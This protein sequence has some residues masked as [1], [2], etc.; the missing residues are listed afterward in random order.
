[1]SSGSEYPKLKD[2]SSMLH[3]ML[4]ET[5]LIKN[6]DNPEYMEILLDGRTCL[7]ELFA[8]IDKQIKFKDNETKKSNDRIMPGFRSV[9]KLKNLPE[10]VIQLFAKRRK[11]AESN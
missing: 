7:E 3:T 2:I 10:R 5:P 4:A 9:M 11:L 8:D 1:M 6:L